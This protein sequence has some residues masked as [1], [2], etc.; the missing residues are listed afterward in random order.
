VGRSTALHLLQQKETAVSEKMLHRIPDQ[1]EKV[2]RNLAKVQQGENLPPVLVQLYW[3]YRHLICR[4]NRTGISDEMLAMLVLMSGGNVDPPPAL[5]IFDLFKKG[6]VKKTDEVRF[7]FR[8]STRLGRIE[9]VDEK[10]KIVSIREIETDMV[11]EVLGSD[12]LLDQ[13]V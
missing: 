8:D 11:R 2:L 13:A 12:V 5:T 1:E 3:A 4:I 10:R 7:R 9:S 6:D